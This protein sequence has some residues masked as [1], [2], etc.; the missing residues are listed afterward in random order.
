MREVIAG[1]GRNDEFD[2]FDH[3]GD[4]VRLMDSKTAGGPCPVGNADREVA[5]PRR[6]V[7]H[8]PALRARGDEPEI[9]GVRTNYEH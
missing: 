2:L 1:G 9:A 8:L 3:P 6:H 5:V 7:L 4:Y